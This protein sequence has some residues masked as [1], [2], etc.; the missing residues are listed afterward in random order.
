L[1]VD[2]EVFGQLLLDQPRRR[3]LEIEK[4]S[5]ARDLAQAVG[6]DLDEIWLISIDGVLSDLDASVRP[7]SRLCFFPYLCGG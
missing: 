2:I 7:G 6:L 4:P 1:P 3:I 5:T